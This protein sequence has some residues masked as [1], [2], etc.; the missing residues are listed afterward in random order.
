MKWKIELRLLGFLAFLCKY[1]KIFKNFL[2]PL[3][4]FFEQNF[5]NNI[6]YFLVMIVV[7]FHPHSP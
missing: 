2:K 3:A 7:G 5:L 4:H 1:R 6:K